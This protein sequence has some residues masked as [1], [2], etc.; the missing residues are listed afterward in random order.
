MFG[1]NVTQKQFF[2]YSL[3]QIA[4]DVNFAN[5]NIE[6]NAKSS[7]DYIWYHYTFKSVRLALSHLI[8]SVGIT[9]F[10]LDY[11]LGQFLCGGD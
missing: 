7:L 1:L 6:L 11:V 4:R 10:D 3:T 9:G 8:L 2:L 5:Q